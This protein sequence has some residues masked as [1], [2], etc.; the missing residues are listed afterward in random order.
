MVKFRLCIAQLSLGFDKVAGGLS[1]FFF[2]SKGSETKEAKQELKP[3]EKSTSGLLGSLVDS[4]KNV[5]GNTVIEGSKDLPSYIFG[6]S[7]ETDK[8]AELRKNADGKV[9][10]DGRT[11]DGR[12]PDG[13]QLHVDSTKDSVHVNSTTHGR[14]DAGKGDGPQPVRVQTIDGR[15]FQQ[16]SD[17]RREASNRQSDLKV[18]QQGD[19]VLIKDKNGHQIA[20]FGSAGDAKRFLDNG[21]IT[22]ARPGE[23][24]ED[25][26]RRLQQ[27]QGERWK[28]N[29]H[30]V[31]DGHGNVL[32]VDENGNTLRRY[33]D[34]RVDMSYRRIGNDGQQSQVNVRVLKRE[35]R[36]VV[37]IRGNDGQYR[38]TAEMTE[39]QVRAQLHGSDLSWVGDRLHRRRCHCDRRKPGEQNAPPADTQPVIG[40][41]GDIQATDNTTVS[42]D[43]GRVQVRE[44]E[45]TITVQADPATG[46]TVLS[47]SESAR[48]VTQDGQGGLTVQGVSFR[49]ICRGYC[50][51]ICHT[52]HC[53]WCQERSSRYSVV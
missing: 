19:R 10:F 38:D 53:H 16:G 46:R 45:N 41:T 3:V 27:E 1:E 51:I 25:A 32:T 49:I 39:A 30:I 43:T 50:R 21:E 22:M 6:R 23:S 52:C 48:T 12:T 4:V 35:G 24:V 37:L 15:E 7:G 17:G 34:G 33:P 13:G 29:N 28:G 2:S 11:P 18:E 47:E 40:A 42:P 8:P 14:I 31:T 44:G 5:V 9:T 26:A 36:T 20:E